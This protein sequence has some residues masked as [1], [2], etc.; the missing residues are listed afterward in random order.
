VLSDNRA[1]VLQVAE[2][3]QMVDIS[4]LFRRAEVAFFLNLHNALM[5]HTHMHRGTATGEPLR[6]IKTRLLKLHQYRVGG[7]FYHMET[8]QQRLLKSRP[9]ARGG[10]GVVEPR[11]HFALSLGCMSS[12]DVRVYTVEN[13]DDELTAAAA[14]LCMRDVQ[15]VYGPS[16]TQT[17]VMPK[18][19]KWFA[20]DFSDDKQ[21][22]FKFIADNLDQAP[23]SSANAHEL[24]LE[25][26][27]VAQAKRDGVRIKYRDFDWRKRAYGRPP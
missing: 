22:L 1:V 8:M 16:G 24:A 3:L 4:L 21:S 25:L 7:Q 15:V 27:A 20:R 6:S 11:L 2:E 19:F 5:L 12:P 26:R 9:G 14:A 17:V 13:L 18:I 23:G 10:S